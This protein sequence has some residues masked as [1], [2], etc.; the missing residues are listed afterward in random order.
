M[1]NYWLKIFNNNID[2]YLITI[3]KSKSIN[4]GFYVKNKNKCII[5]V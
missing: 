3:M 1:T 2:N 5:N 4:T